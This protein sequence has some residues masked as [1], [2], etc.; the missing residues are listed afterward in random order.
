MDKPAIRTDA[1]KRAL[2]FAGAGIRPVGSGTQSQAA[3]PAANAALGVFMAAPSTFADDWPNKPS[4][5]VKIGF[6][7]PSEQTLAEAQMMAS[8]SA[9]LELPNH[10]DA[11]PRQE[12]YASELMTNVLARS[13]VLPNDRS[14]LFFPEAP[15]LQCRVALSSGG[16]RA[17][18]ER[19][20]LLNRQLSPLS[21]EATDDE[22][23]R[24][25]ARLGN[26]EFLQLDAG[27]GRRVRRLLHLVAVE[28]D[29]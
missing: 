10:G 21:P 11:G 23:S 28:L 4:E 13:L 1:L 19:F 17:L 24:L 16:V 8:K 3:I 22:I 25:A 18:W 9:W 29:P 20:E 6:R 12:L 5:P 14:T 2:S 7:L 15:E 27:R 26:G